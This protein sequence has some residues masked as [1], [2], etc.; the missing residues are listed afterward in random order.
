MFLINN[1]RGLERYSVLTFCDHPCEWIWL[2]SVLTS[3]PLIKG[4]YDNKLHPSRG[5]L[6]RLSAK[7]FQMG[8]FVYD[9]DEEKGKAKMYP[10]KL[11]RKCFEKTKMV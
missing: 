6:R 7:E 9:M 2:A 3:E 1:C 10:R 5:S 8:V 11:R 4:Y